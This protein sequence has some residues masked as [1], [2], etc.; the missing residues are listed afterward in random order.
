MRSRNLTIL[1]AVFALCFTSA[2]AAAAGQQK[3]SGPKGVPMAAMD[4]PLDGSDWRMG[5]FEFDEGVKA[6]APTENFN[7]SAFKAVTVPGDTQIQA[8]FTGVE[9]WFESKEL[10]AVNAHE[11]WYRK[12]F[13]AGA[14]AIGGVTHLVFDGSDYFTTVWLNGQLLGTHEGTYTSFEFDVTDKLRYGSDNVLAVEV[15]HPWEPQGRS[16]LEYMNGDFSMA[17]PGAGAQLKKSPFFIGVSWDALPAHGNAAF[18][19]GIWRSVHLRTTSAVTIEDVQVVTQSINADGSATLQLGVTLS[20]TGKE[21]VARTVALT[22]KP[23]NFEGAAQEIPQLTITAAPGSTKAEV[24]VHVAHA[25]LWWSWD[26]GPQNLY[27]LEVATSAEKGLWGDRHTTVFGIRTITRDANMAYWLNGKKIFA[28]ASWFSIEDFYRATPTAESY[29]RDLRLFRDGNFNMLVNFTVVEKPEFYDLCDRLGILDVVELP[30]SQFGPQHVLDYD[31]P[32]REP[33]LKE[34]KSEV[35]QIV[36]L[37]RNHPSVV[38]WAPLAEAHEKAGEWGNG[39]DQKAYDSF[40]ADMKTIITELAPGS[41]FHPSLCDLGEQHFWTAAAGMIWSQESYGDLFS[42]KTG[43]VSEYGGISLSSYENLGKYL[44]P[45][46]QW[47]ATKTGPSWYNIPIDTAAYGYLTSF[48]LNGLYSMLYRTQHYVD[49]DVRSLPEL[50][51]DTQIYQGF[52]LNY[53]A[54]AFRRKKYDPVN[55][56]RSWNFM[57]LGPGFRFGI[58]DYDRVPKMAYWMMKRTQ[59]PVSL[60]FAYK[61]SLDSQ[62]AGSRWTA[63]VWLINDT[64]KE[65]RGTVHA[66][67]YAPSG[68]SVAAADFPASIEAD[69]RGSVGDFSLT[70]PREPGVYILRATLIGSV[71][72]VETSFIKVTPPAFSGSHRVLLIAQSKFADPIAALLRPMGLDVDIYDENAIDKMGS[73]LADGSALRAKYD[74]IWVGCFEALAKVLPAQSAKAIAEAVKAG[75]GFI[76]TG[77]DGSFHGG[78]AHASVVEATA[79][80]DILPVDILPRADLAFGPHGMDDSLPTVNPIKEIDGG[81]AANSESLDLF[82]H[83]GITGFNRVNARAGSQTVLTISG[84]PLLVSGAY[85]AGKTV[86]F[87]GFTPAAD[88]FS[89]FPMDQYMIYE[90]AAR[91]YFAAFADM[92]ARVLPGA[93]VV[94]PKLLAAHEKPLFQTLKEQPPTQLAVTRVNAATGRCHVRIANMGGYAH[95]VHMRYEWPAAGPRPF[96]AEYSDNDFEL[97]PNEFREIDLT[98]RTTVP[99]QRVAGT[100]IVNAANAPEVRLAF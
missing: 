74:V 23:D 42:A 95:L 61:D 30:F 76:I 36:T 11:W 63:P 91:A 50:V 64:G 1:L 20:N 12:H 44:T 45:A 90:P 56:I 87:T 15:T 21:P 48:D 51:S 85:G 97:M 25:Q 81:A 18:D 10:I 8:G 59:A 4:V 39:V 31:N 17:F 32:R 46:Q 9:R 38:E 52:I 88:D 79:L 66:E 2:F 77:G 53:A 13:K 16:L 70:L 100:L 41:I 84:Q 71:A 28:K 37:L 14:K 55:G 7:D 54:Q 73:G 62:L 78:L 27:R 24:E 94:T 26:K 57:E 68:K 96:L 35:K 75:T 5:S 3:Q 67:L 69:G 60:S 82:H 34:A 98:W 93:Q 58:V 72:P 92:L 22:L 40:M 83:Y 49:S 19:M 86:A 89:A 6:G 99:E 65:V 47:G 43:F 29:E 80:N 33:Y